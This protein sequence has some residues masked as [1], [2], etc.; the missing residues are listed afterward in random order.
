MRKKISLILFGLCLIKLFHIAHQ[1]MNFSPH[2]FLNSFK[3]NAGENISLGLT[4][5]DVLPIRDFF[6]INDIKKFKLSNKIIK[7]HQIYYQR[8]LEI[9]YP[10][11]MKKD[12]TILVSHKEEADNNCDLLKVTENFKIYECK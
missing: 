4:A 3:K 6:L 12:A 1:S 8:I 7:N 9:S 2:L 5:S 10:I 11:A